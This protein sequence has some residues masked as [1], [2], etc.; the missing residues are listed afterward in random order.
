MSQ[1]LHIV[2]IADQIQSRQSTDAVP[3]ALEQLAATDTLLPFE[4]TAGD[5]IQGLLATPEAAIDAISLLVRAQVW[6]I[7][8]GVGDVE[9]PLASSTR[10]ARG[11]AYLAARRAIEEAQN[12]ASRIRL[13]HAVEHDE[14]DPAAHDAET[15]L[16]LVAPLVRERTE[17]VWEAVDLLTSG[18]TQT[19]IG[20]ELGIAQS[21]ISR[22]LARAHVEEVNRGWELATRLLARAAGLGEGR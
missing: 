14:A 17:A 22:R 4:R 21:S 12:S 20:E 8:I 7:G 18:K 15:V 6:S 3:D 11:S 9:T 2:L 10:E 1:T 19:Q 16:H 5:E 13:V